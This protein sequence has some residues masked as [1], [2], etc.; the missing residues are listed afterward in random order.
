MNRISPITW[1]AVAIGVIAIP[2]LWLSG[3]SPSPDGGPIRRDSPAAV[4][5]NDDQ[6]AGQRRAA[7]SRP[8]LD[9]Y[10]AIV[11]RPLFSPLRRPASVP[12]AGVEPAPELD[13]QP[14]PI[15]EEPPV[16]EPLAE[17]NLRLVGTLVDAQGRALAIVEQAGATSRTTLALGD[18]VDGWRLESVGNGSIEIRSGDR[19]VR[20]GLKGPE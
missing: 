20:I 2:W 7:P 6:T 15:E 8:P 14:D 5:T 9:S 11:E 18:S 19:L 13:V 1:V 16:G 12:S 4:R 3:D 10:T 17:P